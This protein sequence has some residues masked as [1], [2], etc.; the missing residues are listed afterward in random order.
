MPSRLTAFFLCILL[1]ACANVDYVH[2]STASMP[3]SETVKLQAFPGPI[4]PSRTRTTILRAWNLQG[5]EVVSYELTEK[6]SLVLPAGT[7]RLQL[8]C[9]GLNMAG[10]GPIAD[11][12]AVAGHSYLV[13]CEPS[14]MRLYGRVELIR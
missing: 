6:H 7:Y 12:R 14:G 13:Y 8:D 10:L 5:E 9:G 2:P 4:S 1:A 11:V 3:A